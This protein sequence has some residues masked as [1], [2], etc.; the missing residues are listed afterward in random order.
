MRIVDHHAHRREVLQRIVGRLRLQAGDQREVRRREQDRV[1]VRRGHLHRLGADQAGRARLVVDDDRL[2]EQL[3]ELVGD[4]AADEV[5]GAAGRE[6]HHHAHRLVRIGLRQRGGTAHRRQDAA[7]R[8]R[9][10]AQ[11]CHESSLGSIDAT[12]RGRDKRGPRVP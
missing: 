4:H 7:R 1:A 10:H 11:E 5:G 9:G 6:R 8:N 3:A 12:P 2:A